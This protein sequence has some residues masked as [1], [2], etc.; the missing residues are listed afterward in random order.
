MSG[1][2]LDIV[3]ADDH[4]V[5][6][7]ALSAVLTALGHRVLAAVSGRT[8]LI[9]AV[10]AFQPDVAIIDNCYPDPGGGPNAV[11]QLGSVSSRTRI[12]LLSADGS[13]DALQVALDSGASGYVH[14]TRGI[15]ALLGAL[16]RVVDG[17]VVIEGSFLRRP[18]PKP[19]APGDLTRLATYLTQREVECLTLLTAGLDTATISR[20]L[21]ISRTTVR[22][23]VQAVLTKLGVHSRLEAASLAIRYG[24]VAEPPEC[25][26]T[27][28]GQGVGR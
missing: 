24:L 26:G 22:S 25:A 3:L 9:D 7:D 18:A 5:F 19:T 13:A 2:A 14:K 1:E 16:D 10:R 28:V 4:A 20:R 21:G 15:A 23:H 8:A 17:E 27:A 11:V 6:L 12:V